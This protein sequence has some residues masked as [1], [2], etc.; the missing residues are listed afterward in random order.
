MQ[1]QEFVQGLLAR[2]ATCSEAPPLTHE[3]HL[4]AIWS[5]PA[6]SAKYGAPVVATIAKR[7]EQ[8]EASFIAGTQQI[9]PFEGQFSLSEA[10]IDEIFEQFRRIYGF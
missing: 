8:I 10:G 9:R 4:H 5:G 3:D 6:S 1:F 7:D 2:L